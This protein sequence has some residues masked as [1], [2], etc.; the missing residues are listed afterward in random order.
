[1]AYFY[2]TIYTITKNSHCKVYNN[3]TH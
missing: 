3:R 2:Y 1:M